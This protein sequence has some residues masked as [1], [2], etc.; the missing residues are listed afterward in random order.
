MAARR[1][2]RWM[3]VLIGLSA[4]PAA[5]GAQ[6]I[7]WFKDL[8]QGLRAAEESGR[9]VL[10][11][12]WA[13][14]CAPCRLMDAHVYTDAAVAKAI[15]GRVVAV[16][17]NLDMQPEMVR[18]YGVTTVPHLVVTNAAGTRLLDRRGF[19]N[20]RDMELLVMALP[21]DVAA[22]NRLDRA[23]QADSRD[24]AALAEMGRLLREMGFL[25]ASS[26]AYARALKREDRLGREP[27]EG[28]LWGLGRN[29]LDLADA[30]QAMALLERLAQEY[31]AS[32]RR[33]EY[34]FSLEQARR[35]ASAR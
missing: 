32:A 27:L 17:L 9:P 13:D 26:R 33:A 20:A 24:A 18:R 22:V 16:R 8:K 7:R 29:A 5:M 35:M 30:R 25:E 6:A 14:W 34:L 28:V 10:I 19:L 2:A 21:E 31:P 1:W 15:A 4:A 11:D 12:F 23:L 3:A